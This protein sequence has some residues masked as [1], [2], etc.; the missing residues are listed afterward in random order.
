MLP[1]LEPMVVHPSPADHE[2]R[3]IAGRTSEDKLLGTAQASP[4]VLQERVAL[5][6]A[7]EPSDEELARQALLDGGAD[8]EPTPPR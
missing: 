2:E 5:E 8:N 3:E 4:D 1:A 6:A 7:P